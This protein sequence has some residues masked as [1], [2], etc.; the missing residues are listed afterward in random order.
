VNRA[1]K[2]TAISDISARFSK[3]KAAFLVDFKGMTVEQVTDLRK[4]MHATKA[5]MKVVRNTLALR[6]LDDHPESKSALAESL[7]GNN[8]FIFVNEDPS[9]SAKELTEYGKGVE[10]LV[11]KSGVMEGKVLGPDMIEYLAKLPSK[12]VLRAQL[13][14]TLASPMTTFVRLLN[15]PSSKFVQLL[16]AYKDKQEKGA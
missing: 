2:A 8:A 6:A 13:L 10:Q 9:A 12:E 5:D 14:G 1:D 16:A 15:T 4:K 3:A 11:I 7:V